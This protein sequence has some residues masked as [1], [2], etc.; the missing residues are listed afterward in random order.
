[1]IRWSYAFVDRP[2]ASYERAVRFWAA[3]ADATVS[4]PRGDAGEFA[5]LLPD[6]GDAC[7]KTQAVGGA[8]GTHL[9]LCVEEPAALRERAVALGATVV[10]DHDGWA[11]LRSPGGMAFCAVPWHGEVSRPPVVGADGAQTRIDQV[12]IDVADALADAEIAFW[13]R[14]TGWES[15]PGSLPEFQLIRPPATLPLRLLIQRLGQARPTGAHLDLACA[16]VPAAVAAHER[17]GA[18]V[19][20]H[21]RNWTVLRDPSGLRYCLT[22]R[23]PHTGRLA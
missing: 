11:V 2:A 21:E 8:G 19:E 7:V 4:A 18:T 22:A 23:D 13:A 16:D 6:T 17:L 14:L 1:M 3:V 15:V 9:D 12:A 5:T 20:R 10:A